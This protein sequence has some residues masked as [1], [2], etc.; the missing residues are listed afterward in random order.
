VAVKGRSL[1]RGGKSRGYGVD[2]RTGAKY[3]KVSQSAFIPEEKF[4]RWKAGLNG[5]DVG[6]GAHEAIGR[7]SL[8]L[9]PERGEFPGHVDRHQIEGRSYLI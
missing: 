1:H 6:G 8:D 4:E 9:V 7:P 3:P 2:L 5:Q